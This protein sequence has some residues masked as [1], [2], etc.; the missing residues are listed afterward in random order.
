MFHRIKSTQADKIY[1]ILTPASFVPL[2]GGQNQLADKHYS[3]YWLLLLH[4]MLKLTHIDKAIQNLTPNFSYLLD[5]ID[6]LS[7]CQHV[8]P[9]IVDLSIWHCV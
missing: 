3:T 8:C 4:R 6:S 1:Q 7:P 2:L 5:Q 9:I